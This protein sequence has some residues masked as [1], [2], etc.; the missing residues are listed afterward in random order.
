[1][2]AKE[3]A[4]ALN[5]AQYGNEVTRAENQIAKAQQ[6]ARC[7]NAVCPQ[8]ASAVVRANFTEWAVHLDTMRDLEK[9]IAI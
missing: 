8:M 4:S 9:T 3:M 5:G 1:M 2:T 7:G 6:V